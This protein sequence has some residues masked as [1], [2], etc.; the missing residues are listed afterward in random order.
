MQNPILQC[1]QI[2]PLQGA[3]GTVE[4]FRVV[5]SDIRNFIQSM[6]ATRE[7]HLMPLPRPCTDCLTELNHLV[8]DG[9]FK[10][11]CFVK[12]T[13]YQSNEVKGKK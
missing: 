8:H 11:G 9:K 4:R 5:F 10:R 12:V 1:V 3:S 6:L 2:K 7:S 13:D